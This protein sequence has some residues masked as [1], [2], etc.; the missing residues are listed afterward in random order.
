MG[1]GECL[2]CTLAE[3]LTPGTL[4][5]RTRSGGWP[6]KGHSWT[7]RDGREPP[8]YCSKGQVQL[9]DGFYPTCSVAASAY[10][11]AD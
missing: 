5:P 3:H 9:E 6:R 7:C 8:E 2:A 1:K 11:D 10:A 4:Q